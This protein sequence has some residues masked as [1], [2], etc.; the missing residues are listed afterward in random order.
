MGTQVLLINEKEQLDEFESFLSELDVIGL[1]T[2]TCGTEQ[3]SLYMYGFSVAGWG[4][5]DR[6]TAYIPLRHTPENDLNFQNLDIEYAIEFLKRVTKG[7]K[8]VIHN[9]V[10]DLRVVKKYGVEIEDLEDSMIMAWLVDENRQKGLK[11]LM[12]EYFGKYRESFA[13]ITKKIPFG[14]LPI[15][16][17]LEYGA[18]D[19]IDALDTW[20]RLQPEILFDDYVCKVYYNLY[21]PLARVVSDMEASGMGVNVDA[22]EQKKLLCDQK[23]EEQEKKIKVAIKDTVG[24]SMLVG[25][26]KIYWRDFNINSTQQLATYFF[27]KKKYTSI[28]NTGKKKTPS[29]DLEVIE[30][31]YDNYEDEVAKELL[32]YRYYKGSKSKFLENIDPICNGRKDFGYVYTSW[33]L[34]GT[35]TGRFTS[36]NPPMQ[37]VP[38]KLPSWISKEDDLELRSVIASPEGYWLINP[39]WSQA[40]LRL[41]AHFSNEPV[42][43]DAYKNGEDIHQK[44]ADLCK[45]SR[46]QAKTINFGV[47]YGMGAKTLAKRLGITEKEGYEFNQNYFGM[48]RHVRQFLDRTINFAETHK[49]VRTILGRKR[50]FISTSNNKFFVFKDAPNAKIQGSCA[51]LMMFSLL[52]IPKRFEELKAE[53]PDFDYQVYATVHD[54]FIF[55]VKEKYVPISYEIVKDVME[56]SIKLKVPLVADIPIGRNWHETKKNPFTLE[57][58]KEKVG[59][60][61]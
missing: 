39:D 23:M 31:L 42:L 47:V 45:C 27:E 59:T 30:K 60:Y 19:A 13:E 9:S 48:Y 35:V 49:F 3:P 5:K 17:V 26:K 15:E 25:D 10:F 8:V 36:K 44:T 14:K 58:F 20:I 16:Q 4:D 37:T 28:K 29:V 18:N 56:N 51:D 53:Y 43:K 40:E 11:S 54:E 12:K 24:E 52:H 32:V 34:C 21:L 46:D 6:R 22:L 33:D 1:D 55:A 41:L 61:V 7:R 50:R 57:E 38:K 2:E